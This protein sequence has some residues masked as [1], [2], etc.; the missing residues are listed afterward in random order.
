V[1][2]CDLM[3]C[4]TSADLPTA[5]DPIITG[6]VVAEDMEVWPERKEGR[7]KEKK[8][9]KKESGKGKCLLLLLPS[10]FCLLPSAFCL[11]SSL[12][13]LSSLS[14]PSLSFCLLVFL[15]SPETKEISLFKI[16]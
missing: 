9:K 4:M 6:R 12:S 14:F 3:N 13:S 16:M 11:L 5:A 8:K 10:A 15:S 7:K 2:N 1:I